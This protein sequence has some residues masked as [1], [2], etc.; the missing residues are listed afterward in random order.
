MGEG[1]VEAF[2]IMSDG[3][4][5]KMVYHKTFSSW[6]CTFHF[7]SCTPDGGIVGGIKNEFAS[8]FLLRDKR[9]TKGP[10]CAC[11]HIGLNAQ[12]STSV[13]HIFE[14]PHPTGRKIGN[15][16]GIIALH[17]I[18]R[19][20]FHTTD[21]C[22]GKFGQV[23]IETCGIDSTPQ[24]PPTGVGFCLLRNGDFQFCGANP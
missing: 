23:V 5:V 9:T 19:G 21:A 11:C 12:L 15:V 18:N 14:H 10:S 17:T 4:T 7:L 3:I 22:V 8:G 20:D 6:G 2:K 16:V 13:F 1:G 24:P